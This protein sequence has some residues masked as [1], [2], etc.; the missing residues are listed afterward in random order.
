MSVPGVCEEYLKSD[1]LLAD[2][3]IHSLNAEAQATL[4][5]NLWS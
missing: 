2:V 5:P 3:I 4:W 1:W